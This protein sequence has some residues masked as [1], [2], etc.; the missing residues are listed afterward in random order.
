MRNRKLF[1][2]INSVTWMVNVFIS[3]MD[4]VDLIN[5]LTGQNNY[6]VTAGGC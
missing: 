1:S 5:K 6:T 4:S 3:R 2:P